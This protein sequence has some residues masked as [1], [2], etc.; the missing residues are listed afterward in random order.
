MDTCKRWVWAVLAVVALAAGAAD[1]PMAFVELFKAANAAHDAKDYAGMQRLLKQALKLRP[2]HPAALYKLA[3]AQVLAG[4]RKESLETL[5]QLARMGLTYA[6]KEDTDFQAFAQSERFADVVKQFGRN[7]RPAGRASTVFKVPHAEFIPEGLAYDQDHGTWFIGSAHERSI[8]RVGRDDQPREFVPP[9]GGG[10]WAALGMTVDSKRDVLWVATAAIPE[11]Q[12]AQSDELGKSAILGFD[13]ETGQRKWSH[14][15]DDGKAGHLLGDLT[16]AR[17]GKIYTTD[18]R[19]GIVYELDP[20]TG[21]YGAL[22]HPGELVSPQGIAIW[23]R[24][25]DVLFVA[26]QTQGLYR[27]DLDDKKLTRL[28]VERE[29]CV[30][31]FDGLYAYGDDLIGIQNG[32]RPHRVVHLRLD[33][34]G[35]RIEHADVLVS[36]LPEFDEPT[37]GV[38]VGR[39]FNFV[40]NSQWN[41][42]DANHKLPAAQQLKAPV[43]MRVELDAAE[44]KDRRDD[45]SSYPSR[46]QPGPSQGLPLPDIPIRP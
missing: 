27:Y 26:D 24:D 15:I 10:L 2:E 5:E 17:S 25:R 33:R 14:V 28:E 35:R 46:G 38:V 30:Y 4:E 42:F 19:A 20:A 44:R 7:A 37:L 12:N 6:P 21:K 43:V 23:G 3:A 1:P 39:R 18:S 45:R 31:G 9:G 16:L 41:K 29:I 34:R 13:L 40:A 8:Q 11:M 36:A 32:V 22:T